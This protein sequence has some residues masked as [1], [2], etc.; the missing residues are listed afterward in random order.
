M[1][2]LGKKFSL[3][4]TSIIQQRWCWLKYWGFYNVFF[5]SGM[6]ILEVN[7]GG[8]GSFPLVLSSDLWVW[9]R[10]SWGMS[11][12]WSIKILM[13]ILVVKL[14][15]SRVEHHGFQ[16]Q[17]ICHCLIKDEALNTDILCFVCILFATREF[18]ALF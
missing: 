16:A 2:C 3:F 11:Q 7:W 4:H 1:K 9:I 14:L 17:L 6:V 5:L 15:C 13:I 18:I 12:S 8:F 10:D